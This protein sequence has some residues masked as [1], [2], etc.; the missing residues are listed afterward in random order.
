M[1]DSSNLN[2]L[3]NAQDVIVLCEIVENR[4]LNVF[5]KTTYNSRKGNLASKLRGCIQREQSKITLAL[6]TN[7]SVMEISEKT[8]TGDLSCVNAWLSFDT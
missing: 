6:L 7:N 8:L 1:K 4:F 3:Y 5:G 2:D